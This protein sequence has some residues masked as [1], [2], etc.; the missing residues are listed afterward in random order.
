MRGSIIVFTLRKNSNYHSD[1]VY[2][3]RL[4]EIRSVR[5]RWEHSDGRRSWKNDVRRR[6]NVFTFVW[7]GQ[8]EILKIQ[9]LIEGKKTIWRLIRV[10]AFFRLWWVSKLVIQSLLVVL[11][12][13]CLG[14]MIRKFT[15]GHRW[16]KK[17]FYWSQN[18]SHRP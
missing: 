16:T 7:F 10:L 3:V 11:K 9:G 6:D 2:D 15:C 13:E 17:S 1:D 5:L 18:L 4:L 8:E 12:W 14:S